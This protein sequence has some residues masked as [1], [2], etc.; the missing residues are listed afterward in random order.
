MS[1]CAEVRAIA[2]FEAL[3]AFDRHYIGERTTSDLRSKAVTK[4]KRG[5][6]SI[7]PGGT[8]YGT[9]SCNELQDLPSH[10]RGRG[11]RTSGSL[12]EDAMTSSL[13]VAS[14]DELIVRALNTITLFLP[15]PYSESPQVYDM[16]PHMSI[17]PLLT[18]SQLPELLGILLRNDSV[19][20][21]TSRSDV[22]N[23]MLVLLRRMADCE[24]TLEVCM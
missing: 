16:L 14:S 8:G 4:T 11:T 15:S 20:D 9:G 1:C 5:S 6:A 13:A 21:W 10:R 7:G 23:A 12:E 3:G 2:L 17:Y 18:L 24:L 19:T 22:Y